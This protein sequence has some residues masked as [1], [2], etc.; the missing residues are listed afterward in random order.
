M[1]TAAGII[2]TTGAIALINEGLSAPY[3]P[4]NTNVL[5]SINWRVIPATAIAAF[6]FSG[7]E[8]VNGTAARGLAAIALLA[9]LL[10][11]IDGKPSPVQNISSALGY[12]SISVKYIPT[13]GGAFLP[14]VTEQ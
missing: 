9:S 2:I 8:E 7:F 11:G 6:I 5:T 10:I 12:K 4:G 13:P 3:T 1:A 14:V